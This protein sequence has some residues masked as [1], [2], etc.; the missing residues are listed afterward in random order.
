MLRTW[1]ARSLENDI[2]EQLVYQNLDVVFGGGW[3]RLLPAPEGSRTDGENLLEVLKAR[4]YQWVQT[5]V[6]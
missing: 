1:T 5:K 6:R 4:G 3:D 2:A